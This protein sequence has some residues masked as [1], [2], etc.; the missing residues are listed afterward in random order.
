M[1]RSNTPRSR[2]DHTLNASETGSHG[3]G[4]HAILPDTPPSAPVLPK[5]AEPAC[6]FHASIKKFPME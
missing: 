3:D 5:T 4:V 1:Y 2:V 6:L